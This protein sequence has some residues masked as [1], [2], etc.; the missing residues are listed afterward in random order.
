MLSLLTLKRYQIILKERGLQVKV[1]GNVQAQ[2]SL[3]AIN[4]VCIDAKPY[5]EWIARELK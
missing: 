3:S 5:Q 1:W 2:N 4:S